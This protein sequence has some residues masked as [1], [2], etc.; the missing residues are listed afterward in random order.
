MRFIGDIHGKFSEYLEV[1]RLCEESVQVGDFGVGFNSYRSRYRDGLAREFQRDHPEHKFI[2]GN[3]DNPAACKT[4]PGYIMD[5][6]YDAATGI[7]YVGGAWSIDWR[8]RTEGN[9]WWADEELSFPDLARVHALYVYHKPRIM[10]THDC[11][12]E[13]ATELFF[14]TDFCK[15]Q[16]HTRTADMLQTMLEE[17]RPDLWIFGHWHL[18]TRKTIRGCEFQCLAELDHID[19][20]VR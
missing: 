17:H 19:V 11:P 4:M 5:G 1:V 18:T 9:D 12:H 20:D 15:S 6:T 2:R 8:F 3:H 10:V 14:D 7:M 13:V 16:T